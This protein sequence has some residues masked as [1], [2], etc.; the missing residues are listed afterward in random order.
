M[1]VPSGKRATKRN[2]LR[3]RDGDNC[4]ICG[5]PMRFAPGNGLDPEFATLDHVIPKSRGGT[6]ALSNLKLAHGRCNLARGNSEA[7][8]TISKGDGA[9]V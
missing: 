2:Q 8:D 7:S 1:A 9:S 6:A 3:M 5:E 4:W